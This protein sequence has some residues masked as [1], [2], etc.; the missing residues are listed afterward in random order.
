M[1]HLSLYQSANYTCTAYV[2]SR[3]VFE[4]IIWLIFTEDQSYVKLCP[5]VAAILDFLSTQNR[6]FVE[7]YSSR[8]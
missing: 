6:H 1:A 4:K 7:D 8:V 3:P 5:V 2:Q